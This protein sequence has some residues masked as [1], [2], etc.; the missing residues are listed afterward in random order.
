MAD[1]EKRLCSQGHGRGGAAGAVRHPVFRGNRLGRRPYS[2]GENDP[3]GALGKPHWLGTAHDARNGTGTASADDA[4][5][6]GGIAA[7]SCFGAT[8]QVVV[9]PRVGTPAPENVSFLA[10]S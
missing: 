6:G 1:W 8:A 4:G 5:K 10:R 7:A 9:R 3:A 2:S